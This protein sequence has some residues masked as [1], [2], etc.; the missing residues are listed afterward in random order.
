MTF[1]MRWIAPS[2]GHAL[3]RTLLVLIAAAA[4]LSATVALEGWPTAK[5]DLHRDER[6]NF[7]ADVRRGP[8]ALLTE[9]VFIAICAGIGR[10]IFQIRL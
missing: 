3:R 1:R 4:V 5:R 6:L 2:A 9:V 10:R 7:R 8:I